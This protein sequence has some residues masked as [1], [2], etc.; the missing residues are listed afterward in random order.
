MLGSVIPFTLVVMT[1]TNKQLVDPSLDRGSEK[2]ARLL[3]RWGR[4]HWVRSGAS[5]AAL[6]VF[7]YLL[8]VG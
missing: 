2:A 1:S 7:M 5:L 3:S 8:V 6:L 4:L